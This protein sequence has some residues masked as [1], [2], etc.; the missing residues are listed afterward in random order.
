MAVVLVAALS[1]GVA[2]Y[3]SSGGGGTSNEQPKTGNLN[4]TPR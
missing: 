1:L 2:A 4:P 3:G